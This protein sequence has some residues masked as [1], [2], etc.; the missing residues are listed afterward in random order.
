MTDI[1][2]N[3]AIVNNG[4]LLKPNDTERSNAFFVLFVNLN[5]F[6]IKEASRVKV[7]NAHL[8]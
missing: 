6:F 5:L 7:Q 1:Q 2:Y 3:I 4:N 8:E